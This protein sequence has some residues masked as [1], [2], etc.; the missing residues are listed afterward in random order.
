L[1]DG[2]SKKKAQDNPEHTH[3]RLIRARAQIL[4]KKARLDGDFHSRKM[5]IQNG[6]P[7]PEVVEQ[8]IFSNVLCFLGARRRALD[9]VHRHA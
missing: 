7:I 5:A 1:R 2:A 3:K 4:Q 8:V 6:I 9:D